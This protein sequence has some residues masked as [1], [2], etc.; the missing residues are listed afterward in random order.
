MEQRYLSLV[1]FHDNEDDS[2]GVGNV[3]RGGQDGG[4]ERDGSSGTPTFTTAGDSH[5]GGCFEFH[6]I[7]TLRQS[8]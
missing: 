6:E 4:G 1:T 3:A 2:G 7:V 8:I 5:N